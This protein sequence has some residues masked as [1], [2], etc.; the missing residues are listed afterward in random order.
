MN[1]MILPSLKQR[2]ASGARSIMPWFENLFLS[3]F[4]ISEFWG[5]GVLA[6]LH[7]CVCFDLKKWR[8]TICYA[9]YYYVS[10]FLHIHKVVTSHLFNFWTWEVIFYSWTFEN[11]G[12]VTNQRTNKKERTRG[13]CE[14]IG[15]HLANTWLNAYESSVGLFSRRRSIWRSNFDP[16]R[17]KGL[18]FR[19]QRGIV[20]LLSWT[21]K[22]RKNVR[23]WPFGSK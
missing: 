19:G 18:N 12:T 17:T 7:L 5:E 1:S 15:E 20:H 23:K 2:K 6:C 8:H 16:I 11:I 22:N 3:P 14:Q 4:S 21:K 9:Y 13:L 10:Y